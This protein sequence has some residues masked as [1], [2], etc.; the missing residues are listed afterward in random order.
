MLTQDLR[1]SYAPRTYCHVVSPTSKLGRFIFSSLLTGCKVSA[2]FGFSSGQGYVGE[3]LSSQLILRSQS[4][5]TAAP[6]IILKIKIAFEGGLKDLVVEHD[7]SKRSEASTTDGLVHFQSIHLQRQHANVVTG[8]LGLVTQGKMPLVGSAN[9]KLATSERKCLSFDHVPR[10]AGD[11][12]VTS[13]TLYM[14][15]D[16]YDLEITITEDDQLN[17]EVS[18]IP[19]ISGLA[20]KPLKPGRSNVVKILP[21]PPKLNV[22]LPGL[23]P[24]YFTDEMVALELLITNEEEDEVDV[25]LDVRMIGPPGQRPDMKWAS[26]EEDVGAFGTSTHNDDPLEVKSDR[27]PSKHIGSLAKSAIERKTVDIHTSSEGAEYLLEIKASYYLLSDP[28][29]PIVKSFSANL[30]VVLPFEASYTFS[31]LLS[32]EPW[33]SYFD[34]DEPLSTDTT[35]EKSASGEKAASG[36]TQRWYL[37]SRIASLADVPLT[38]DAVKPRVLAVHENATCKISPA[39]E[40]SPSLSSISPNDLQERAFIIEA[41]KIELDDRQ[42]AFLN[43]QLEIPWRRIGSLGPANVTRLA[44]SELVIPFGEPRVL[45]SARNGESPP[46]VIHLDYI[47]ENP[48]MYTLNFNLTMETSEEFAFSGLKNVSVQLV[49]LS[50]HTTRYNLMPLVKGVWITPQF[51]VFDTHFRKTLKV[52]ATEGMR[53]ESKGVQIWANTD[54]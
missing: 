16:A 26:T 15:E 23:L 49:P 35:D 20:P 5:K 43:L 50:R 10:D 12:E 11:V 31:P 33:P 6:I 8:S 25:T 46:G 27:L 51:R 17:Q 54:D 52:N 34:L 36:L 3:P 41:Q 44:V 37:T 47:I 4:H 39:A 42:S 2:T 32:P 7:G 29:T 18:W 45:A 24:T 38:I 19:S 40:S 22:E 1:L 13:I 48:S 30:L 9:L 28:E 21:K 53:T 14:R